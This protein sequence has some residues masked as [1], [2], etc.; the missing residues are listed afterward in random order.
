[1]RQGFLG[2]TWLEDYGEA[3]SLDGGRNSLSAGDRH[4][5]GNY[6]AERLRQICGLAFV[7]GAK[8]VSMLR[9]HEPRADRGETLAV[10]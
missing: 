8:E 5:P 7:N 2:G 3:H 4:S 6:H 10:G 1:M 9:E